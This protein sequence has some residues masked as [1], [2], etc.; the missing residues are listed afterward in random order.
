MVRMMEKNPRVGILQTSPLAVNKESLIA[1]VQQFSNHVYGPMFVAGLY[2]TQL[3]DS[4]FWGHNAI[5]R[6][7]PFM[8]HCGLPQLPG[9]PP[10]GGEIL[11]HDFVE[12]ALMRKAGY[13]VWLAYDLGGS[14]EEVPPT[15]LEELK[16][17]RRWCQGN[18]QHMRL[19]F[20]EGLFPAHRALFLHG[21]MAYVSALLWFLFLSLSTAEAIYEVVRE[22][23]Y[24]PAGRS[25][26][27]QWPVWH[28]Q[29]ALTLLATTAVILFLPKLLS[30]L[31]IIIKGG[32]RAF[33]GVLRLLLSVLAEVIFSTLFAP[34]RMLFHSKFVFITLLGQQVGWGSQ[35]RSD[36][37]TGWGEAARFHGA[38][39]VVAL[40]WGILL[41]LVN[42]SFFWWNMPVFIPV[43][44]SIP[45][46]VWSSR[47]TLGRYS[48]RLGLFITPEEVA[49]PPEVQN[50]ER[51]EEQHIFL[52]S[53]PMEREAGFVRAVVDPR[54]NFLH[55]S[56]LRKE[57]TVSPSIASRRQQLQDKALAGGPESLSVKE[58]KELLYDSRCMEELHHKVW[59]ITDRLQAAQWSLAA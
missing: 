24:F 26:F 7:E 37:G 9:K 50:L 43:I 35:Q 17:D 31:V 18:M 25:L 23:V 12:A 4:H 54:V 32:A 51:K 13:E 36:L 48:R 42:R 8:Q 15:L 10:L 1:R 38:G 29:W 52:S 2:F 56:L 40:L 14:Y 5:L 57:R 19:L 28:P 33:G 46:S 20:A 58:K 45:L 22:P 47:A 6:I 44:L 49:P 16:R 55:R 21:A 59:E 53:L 27:P 34:V 30:V 41:F 39:T 3:G 11:S